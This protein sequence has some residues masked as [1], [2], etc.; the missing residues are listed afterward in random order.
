V[1]PKDPPPADIAK[2]KTLFA[3]GGKSYEK[4]DYAAAIQAFERSYTLSGRPS[5]LFS[6]GQ[7]YK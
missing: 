6:L 1:A 5:V 4:G 2:A 7:A 3:A